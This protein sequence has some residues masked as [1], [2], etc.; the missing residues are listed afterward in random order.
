MKYNRYK[1]HTN[2]ID[3]KIINLYNKFTTEQI[4]DS[5]KNRNWNK[6]D[7]LDKSEKSIHIL[8]ELELYNK[9]IKS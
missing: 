5:R 9:F 6:F 4:L 8:Q 7:K 2:F 1:I 3:E